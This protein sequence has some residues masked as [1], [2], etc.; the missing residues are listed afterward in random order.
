MYTRYF[1]HVQAE[2]ATCPQLSG[3][4]HCLRGP[5]AVL[6]ARQALLR[7]SLVN[8]LSERC[9]GMPEVFRPKRVQAAFGLMPRAVGLRGCSQNCGTRGSWNDVISL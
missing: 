5:G 8:R 1:P 6:S 2:A 7:F 3:H 4:R 9:G